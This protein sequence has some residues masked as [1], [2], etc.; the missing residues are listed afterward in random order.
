[1][2]KDSIVLP[3]VRIGRDCRIT[4]AII[5]EGVEISDGSVIGSE[6]GGITVVGESL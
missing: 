4:K 6:D 3:G 2:V 1:M 5:N